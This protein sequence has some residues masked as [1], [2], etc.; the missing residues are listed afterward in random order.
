MIALFRT[1]HFRNFRASGIGEI[2]KQAVEKTSKYELRQMKEAEFCLNC[3]HCDD[4]KKGDCRERKEFK[5][6]QKK[7]I[8]NETAAL[9]SKKEIASVLKCLP[10]EITLIETE[11][12]ENQKP[13]FYRFIYKGVVYRLIFGRLVTD[14][15]PKNRPTIKN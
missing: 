12:N 6:E 13:Y 14:Y 4:C 15:N 9:K 3:K 8:D 5:K 7:M 1:E 10:V 11:E 2:K